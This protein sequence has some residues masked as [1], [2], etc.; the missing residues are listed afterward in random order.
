MKGDRLSD[1][2]LATAARETR[3]N[4]FGGTAMSELH[5]LE[6]FVTAAHSGSF[7][8]TASRMR[9]SVAAVS[10]AITRLEASMD[11]RLFNRTT[12]RLHLTAEG[13]LALTEVMAGMDRLRNARVL[14]QDQRQRPSGTIKVLLPIAFAKHYVMPEIPAVLECYPDIDID[15]YIEDFGSDLLAGGYDVVVQHRPVPETGYISRSLGSLEIA[16]LASPAYLKRYGVPQT[17]ADLE[18]HSRIQIRGRANGVK[19][20]GFPGG[21]YL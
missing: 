7:T 4:A 18:T 17:I 5:D 10:R 20:P 9:L 2:G 1:G 11:S 21:S 13:Q 12:R 14:L 8:E 3:Y 16:L 19:R 6:I 15:M